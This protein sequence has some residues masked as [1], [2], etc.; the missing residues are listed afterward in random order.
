MK[1]TGAYTQAPGSNSL[2]KRHCGE[3]L[4]SVE[5]LDDPAVGKTKFSL[6]TG[7]VNGAEGSLGRDSVGVERPNGSP[8]P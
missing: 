8:C 1:T 7:V 4:T 5:D 3:V 2:A 6:V